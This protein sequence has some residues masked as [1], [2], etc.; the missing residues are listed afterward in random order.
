MNVW[1]AWAH[2]L[3]GMHGLHGMRGG[4][5]STRQDRDFLRPQLASSETANTW[6][7]V[8]TTMHLPNA[9]YNGETMPML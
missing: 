7:D 2:V 4:Q 6:Q 9:A 8:L 1:D 3:H 5:V